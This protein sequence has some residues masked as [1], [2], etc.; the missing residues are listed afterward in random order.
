MISILAPIL[1]IG[2]LITAHEFGHCIVAKLSGVRVHL[3]SIG[4]GKALVKWNWGETEYR[5][6]YFPF[7]GYVRMAG[8][9]PMEEEEPGT[10][11][12]ADAGRS[13]FDTDLTGDVALIF[14]NEG[15]GVTPE[16]QALAH[17]AV[18]IPMPG[19][20][21]SLNVGAAAAICLFER[22][23]QIKHNAGQH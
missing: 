23:R 14:G 5:I 18:M 2:V 6:A 11:D 9:D 13:L 7:G 10:F 8:Q 15:A 12:P 19:P 4:F 20:I 1:L 16:L 3:F 21:E 22:V 17:Q